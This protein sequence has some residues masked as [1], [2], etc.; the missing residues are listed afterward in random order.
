MEDRKDVVVLNQENVK[1]LISNVE[2]ESQKTNEKYE[3]TK[4]KLK[5]SR[6]L[7]IILAIF[8]FIFVVIFG[9]GGFILSIIYKNVKPHF[10]ALMGDVYNVASVSQINK[11]NIINLDHF[12]QKLAFVDDVVSLS[13]YYDKDNKKIE[14]E[15]FKG[16]VKALG[17]RYAEY[18]PAQDFE[19]FTR[20]NTEGVYYGI[21]CEVN[22]DKKSKDCAIVKV[23]EGSPAETAGLKAKDVF[24]SVDGKSVKG[25]SLEE[26]VDLIKGPA[27]IERKIVV[28]RESEKENV[29]VTAY[30]GVVDIKLI[31]SDIYEGNI[32]YISISQ[33]TGKASEQF[34]EAAD[35]LMAKDIKG[36][37][38]DCRSNPG[39][40]LRTVCEMIDYVLKDRDGRYTLNQEE[41]IFEPGKTLIYYSKEKEQIVEAGYCDDNHSI[42]IP[43][44]VL[45]DYSTASAAE[46]FSAALRDYRRAK[47]V[48]IKTFGKGVMQNIINL[49]D[50]S[51]IKFTVAE[52]F[53]PSGYSI[54][55][56]GI[57]PD[58]SLDAVGVEVEY[59]EQNHIVL[60]EDN[61]AI[62]FDRDG[63]IIEEREIEVSTGSE[64]KKD[65]KAHVENLKIYDEENKFLDE[66]WFI[67]LDDK[68]Q[69]K[70]ILQAIVIL[71]DQIK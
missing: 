71:R 5:R 8:L 66:D 19:E 36:L 65:G 11:E 26:I 6:V 25:L 1:S 52:Y 70:Q 27:G 43:I 35:K 33:F 69:D 45:T 50:G 41:Q 21:G 14:D 18:M 56:K 61:K 4:K 32:G 20:T 9:V 44:V 31:T 15:M 3:K 2:V 37:I 54:D 64:I 38:I 13:Y 51:A 46:L 39:G 7:N 30:C 57:I 29:E 48:G 68:Y 47:I 59:D 28:Y 10:R 12:I 60:Y 62:V 58:Y 42:D 53:P 63:A 16:Y 34:I 23:Y 24:V 40:E 55:L 22:F 67:K 17:D 49:D